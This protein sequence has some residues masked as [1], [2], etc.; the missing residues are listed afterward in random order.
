MTKKQMSWVYSPSKAVKP[1]ISAGVKTTVERQAQTLIDTVLKP[2]HSQPPPPDARFNYIVDI[3]S[4]WYRNYFYFCAQYACP[5]PNALSPSFE[6]KFARLSTHSGLRPSTRSHCH[7]DHIFGRTLNPSG[8]YRG[9]SHPDGVSGV[10][11][12]CRFQSRSGG[13]RQ[14]PSS[15]PGG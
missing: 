9:A 8:R 6:A 14:S 5:G 15:E 10:A 1:Q 4:K 7:I 12:L 11:R 13:E 3:T 2:K